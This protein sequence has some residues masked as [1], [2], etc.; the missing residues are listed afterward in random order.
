MV[1]VI[2]WGTFPRQRTVVGTLTTIVELTAA[3]R[4]SPPSVIVIGPIVALREQLRWFDRE[5]DHG[6][7]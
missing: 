3:A 2:E 1:A 7:T 6:S 5:Q 4:F